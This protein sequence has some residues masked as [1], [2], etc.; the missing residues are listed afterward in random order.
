MPE[1]FAVIILKLNLWFHHTLISTKN[2][3]KMAKSIDPDQTPLDIK[4][5]QKQE[6]KLRIN[7]ILKFKEDGRK[8]NIQL[9]NKICR[10]FLFVKLYYRDGILRQEGSIF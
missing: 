7:T 3:A 5:V 2:D 8:F 1:K 4:S 10:E 6:V 9:Y